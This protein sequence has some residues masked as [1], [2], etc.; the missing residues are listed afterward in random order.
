MF[1]HNTIHS[2][3]VFINIR[4]GV[5]VDANLDGGVRPA[6]VA[7]RARGGRGDDQVAPRA[8]AR[9]SAQAWI[10]YKAL[11]NIKDT[12]HRKH[13]NYTIR[14]LCIRLY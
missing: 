2:T 14:A 12:L 10:A 3:Q 6:E 4:D 13:C 5:L 1:L 9:R 7:Q 8:A 11:H